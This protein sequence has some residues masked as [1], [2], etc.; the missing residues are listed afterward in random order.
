[1]TNAWIGL[2]EKWRLWIT[3]SV[4]GCVLI[5]AII[6]TLGFVVAWDPN[7]NGRCFSN[8][9]HSQFPKWVGCAMAVHEGLA[10]S[11]I[12]AGG[13]LFGAWLAFSALQEQIGMTRKNQREAKRLTLERDVQDN[14]RVLEQMASAKTFIDSMSN[15]FSEAMTQRDLGERLLQFFRT[16]RLEI[17]TSVAEVPNGIGQGIA[18]M[19][20]QLRSIAANLQNEIADIE[21]ATRAKIVETRGTEVAARIDAL[22]QCSAT[23]DARKPAYEARYQTAVQALRALGHPAPRHSHRNT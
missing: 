4:I 10:G 20:A 11:L 9:H 18:T 12:A 3:R 21:A 15:A 16:G 2:I 17:S 23:I 22:R 8:I 14:S 5:A 19:M 6:S 13:A 1:M 7:P